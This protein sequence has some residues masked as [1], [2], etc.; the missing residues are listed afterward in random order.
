MVVSTEDLYVYKYFAGYF[1]GLNPQDR[2]ILKGKL[3]ERLSSFDLKYSDGSN[4][5]WK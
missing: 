3:E 1:A 2:E 4:R 5:V